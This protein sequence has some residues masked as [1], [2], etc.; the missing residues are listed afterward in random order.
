[1]VKKKMKYCTIEDV[2]RLGFKNKS[3]G[4]EYTEDEVEEIINKYIIQASSLIE[5][6]CHRKWTD[7]VPEGITL[8]TARLVMNIV[9]FN[10][11]RRDNPIKK[12][13]D[14]TTKIFSS[15]VF[16]DDIRKD[17]NPFRKVKPPHVFSI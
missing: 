11:S 9:A 2:R 14:Y 15:E 12:V 3:L 13:N 16:S 8:C 6:Y 10:Q 4:K 5:Q 7:N 1:M 17:L